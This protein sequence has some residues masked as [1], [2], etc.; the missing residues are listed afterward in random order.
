VEQELQS[1][2]L[3]TVSGIL[4]PAA[5]GDVEDQESGSETETDDEKSL[6]TPH[7]RQ[8]PVHTPSVS[9]DDRKQEDT[10]VQAEVSIPRRT[11][12]MQLPK[13]D[14]VGHEA[15]L[16]SPVRSQTKEN[17]SQRDTVKPASST[18]SNS[19]RDRSRSRDRD[20]RRSPP[21]R[22]SPSPPPRN[23]RKGESGSD[24]VGVWLKGHPKL[25]RSRKG[26]LCWHFG[27]RG[28]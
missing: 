1:S 28:G 8:T 22:R 5:P 19:R 6:S 10:P 7:R 12:S 9:T 26:V 3:S 16:V 24:K 21:R 4:E 2:S 23:G 18:K 27:E 25:G 15:P 11:P 17:T 13:T 14:A 20:R